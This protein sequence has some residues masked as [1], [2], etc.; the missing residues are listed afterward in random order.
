MS[1]EFDSG[2]ENGAVLFSI[3]SLGDI[4]SI[5]NATQKIVTAIYV[6]QAKTT[7]SQR[8]QATAQSK[9]HGKFL[10]CEHELLSFLYCKCINHKS[11]GLQ[12]SYCC[13]TKME[14]LSLPLI[15]MF[16][17]KIKLGIVTEI[18]S[19]KT[20][21]TPVSLV[22]LSPCFLSRNHLFRNIVV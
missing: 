22:L 8:L 11:I 2:N 5:P 15:R 9:K 20:S 7:I 3:M 6:G 21:F 10:T 13:S 18:I 1:E 12:S 14:L 17:F 4:H 16:I 19:L